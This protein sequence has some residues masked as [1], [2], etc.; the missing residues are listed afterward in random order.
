MTV[1]IGE[2]QVDVQESAAPAPTP[3][4]ASEEPKME[5][6]LIQALDVLRERN[7]RLQVD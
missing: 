6:P 1:T 5:M 7:L 2:M 3:V 4:S